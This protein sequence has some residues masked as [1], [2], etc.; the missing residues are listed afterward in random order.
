MRFGD[1]LI[2][3]F[4]QLV[5]LWLNSPAGSLLQWTLRQFNGMI[6]G[7][8]VDATQ[9]L[10]NE[11]SK[12][13]APGPMILAL[14]LS[15][16][17]GKP[18]PTDPQSRAAQLQHLMTDPA[19]YMIEVANALGRS[20]QLAGLQQVLGRIL[21]DIVITPLENTLD[22]G[23]E[24]P[25]LFSAQFH[26][27]LASLTLA[28]HV[29][30]LAAEIT[31]L[32]QIET[33]GRAISDLYFNFGLGFMGWQTISPLLDIGVKEAG[34]RYYQK[35]YRPRR[36]TVSELQNLYALNEITQADLTAEMQIAGYRDQD[37][38]LAVKLS[39]ARIGV[40]DV[41]D[42]YYFGIFD[43]ASTLS[44]IRGKGYALEDAN[45]LIQLEDVRKKD[46]QL[47][48]IVG[49]ARSAFKKHI[50]DEARFR[51]I[52]TSAHFSPDRIELEVA[53]AQAENT[54]DTKDLNVGQVKAAFVQGVLRE[55]EAVHYLQQIRIDPAAVPLL[56][57]TWK[58]ELVPVPAKLNSGTISNA[59]V[60]GVLTRGEAASRLASVG[61]GSGDAEVILKLADV[62]I[63]RIRQQLQQ[64]QARIF[65]PSQIESAF[66]ADVLSSG[67]ASSYLQQYGIP[68][69][70]I[71]ILLN[72][73]I[74]QKAGQ[75]RELSQEAIVS[76][77]LLGLLS[78]DAA[79]S[80]L[81]DLGLAPEDALLA[82]E[83]GETKAA[84]AEAARQ[85]A[86]KKGITPGIVESA[87][88]AGV[89]DEAKSRQLLASIK[90]VE[91][92]LSLLVETWKAE[93]VI[94]P[95]LLSPD[96]VISAYQLDVI[97]R[98]E[99][100]SR[101]V[102][103]GLSAGDAE[104]MLKTSEARAAAEAAQAQARLQKQI[105]APVIE[106]AYLRNVI[107]ESKVRELLGSIE[108]NE[109]L[110]SLLI[111]TW[112]DEKVIQPQVLSSGAIVTAYQF[113]ILDRSQTQ[114]K[115]ASLRVAPDDIKI[116][117]S[118]AERALA[119]TTPRPGENDIVTAYSNGILSYDAAL[120]QL[121][122][123]G[124]TSENAT[125]VLR[126]SEI[127]P[128]REPKPL[129]E[130]TVIKLIKQGVFDPDEA[131]RR[132]MLLGYDESN[133]ELVLVSQLTEV[134]P[135]GGGGG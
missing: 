50:I 19:A 48:A 75:T 42:G 78:R 65:S 119:A 64:Q 121:S 21:V 104:L 56:I 33:V 98:T 44:R 114:A 92:E 2:N 73:W 5:N 51:S 52:L 113:G 27:A 84:Q 109:P 34:G 93:L 53:A 105:T 77:Y 17:S 96:A 80:R 81:E 31:G 132:L 7:K 111:A 76:A 23:A 120:S 133:A 24:D 79:L 46:A 112:N 59:Y 88:K 100:A 16:L 68:G 116:I 125:F 15:G 62:E 49:V 70:V 110:L 129:S 108:V 43:A 45:I 58:A 36:W 115:L 106:Q 63:A 102:A 134:P 97:S 29:F 82:V 61:W 47:S 126:A 72:T 135:A 8:P 89:I 95:R 28:G 131:I 4:K 103:S 66:K 94:A 86:A 123:L 128:P 122:T 85:A 87:F 74:A 55:P 67:Q 25:K 90:V 14:V 101:L 71:T 11:L 9:L 60:K 12:I 3:W 32:G 130:S 118:I 127:A 6:R 37:I 22:G 41:L 124:Y 35:R 54:S 38:A 69:P 18:V 107:D 39:Q 26:G 10:V 99:A 1:V 91:P 57:A 30:S 40:G 117:L 13:P 83:I 20:P